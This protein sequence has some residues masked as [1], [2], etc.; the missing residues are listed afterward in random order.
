[1]KTATGLIALL[2][3]PLLFAGDVGDLFAKVLDGKAPAITK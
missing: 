1:M 3:A 2:L